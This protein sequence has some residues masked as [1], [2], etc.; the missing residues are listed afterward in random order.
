MFEEWLIS[1]VDLLVQNW[2]FLALSGVVFYVVSIIFDRRNIPPG[3]Y[4]LPLVGYI[5]FLSDNAHRELY[6]LS[7]KYGK[8]FW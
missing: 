8:V 6:D 1:T 2:A 7:E 4:G 5:P 3:P